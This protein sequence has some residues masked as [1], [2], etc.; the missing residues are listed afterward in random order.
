MSFLVDEKVSHSR[1]QTIKIV[2]TIKNVPFTW[3][4]Y[5]SIKE[6]YADLHDTVRRGKERNMLDVENTPVLPNK[7]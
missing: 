7:W 6:E 5:H 3:E 4:K 1:T 2:L